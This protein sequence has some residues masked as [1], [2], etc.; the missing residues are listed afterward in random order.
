M[1]VAVVL[2]GAIV[3]LQT[4]SHGARIPAHRPLRELPL[5]VDDWKAQDF[6]LDQDTLTVVRVDDY[7]NRIY[8]DPA[9]HAIGLYIGYYTNQQTGDII[10]S[11]K[12]CL[13]GAGWEP[14]R[15]DYLQIPVPAS[16]PIV[17]N[18][19]VIRKGLDR[20]LVLYWYQARGRVIA[21]EYSGKAWMVYDAL[22]KN[23]T[24]GALVRI[25]TPAG[26]SDAVAR[27]RAVRFVDWLYPQLA[28]YLPG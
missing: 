9:G 10:H 8:H 16:A 15:S 27:E 20:E 2:V 18:Q 11:P 26:E 5:Q 13:P 19:Y 14:V 3:L 28:S 25:F 22:T 12:N 17:V 21:S 6:P 1:I 23:R 24:D 4:M 7:I